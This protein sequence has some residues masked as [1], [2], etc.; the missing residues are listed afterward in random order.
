MPYGY[1]SESRLKMLQGYDVK[2]GKE[3]QGL[4][5]GVQNVLSMEILMEYHR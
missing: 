4:I 1:S 5:E 2:L 3:N